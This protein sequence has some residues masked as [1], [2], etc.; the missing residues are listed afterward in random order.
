MTTYNPHHAW[1]TATRIFEYVCII[2][3]AFVIACIAGAA[4]LAIIGI[5]Q[6]GLLAVAG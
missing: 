2:L 3:A 4:M 1:N 5:L 6:L